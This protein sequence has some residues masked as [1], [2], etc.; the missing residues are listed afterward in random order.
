MGVQLTRTLGFVQVVA[1]TALGLCGLGAML[2]AA[3]WVDG[4]QLLERPARAQTAPVPAQPPLTPVASPDLDV[5][6]YTLEARLDATRHVIAGHGEIRWRNDATT[7][8]HE[9]WMHLYLNA[10]KNDKTLF[11]RSPYGAGRSGAHASDWGYIDV[12][13]LVARELGN[14]DLWPGAA[15]TSPGDPDDQT[16]IR[17]P[18]PTP[19]APGGR[20]TL[21]V[22]FD[23]KLPAILERTGYAGSFHFAGQ[24]FPKL[25]RREPDGSWAHFRFD[26]QSE[27]YADFGSYDVTIDVPAEMQV[28]ASGVRRSERVARGRRVVRHTIAPAHDFAWTAWDQFRVATTTADG[29]AVRLLYPPSQEAGARVTL[30]ALERALPYM[31]RRYGRY[32]YPTLTVVSPPDAAAA[33]GG[34][35]YPS[36]ITSGGRWYLPHL[37]IRAFETV[38]IHELGHQWFYGTVATNEHQW[39]FLDEGVNSYAESNTMTALYGQGSAI[40]ALGVEVSGP[41]LMRAIAALRAHDVPIALG[42][43]RFPGF[44]DLAALVYSRTATLLTTLG[45]V[46]GTERLER[47]LGDYARRNRFGHPGPTE[48]VA[49]LRTELGDEAARAAQGA[50]F[51]RGW[52]DYVVRD[53]ETTPLARPAGVFDSDAGRKEHR[54]VERDDSQPTQWVGRVLVFRHGNLHFPVDIDLYAEDGSTTRHRWDGSGD[55]I[56]LD[57][58]GTSPLVGAWIDP[59]R[60]VALDQDLT[61]NVCNSRPASRARILERASYAAFLLLSGLGT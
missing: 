55:W 48:L 9:L 38:T 36:L 47:A 3:A 60:K 24:W 22:S 54:V 58:R 11:L 33:A 29:V 8:A 13:R 4:A 34:M 41:A 50:L 23:A 45:N 28:G 10:F 14:I 26:A 25:A 42:A 27:F 37:G 32:P 59:R 21:A 5:A 19:V 44:E 31:N 35:E 57:Y 43:A 30:D 49:A 46:Y 51:E 2:W 39:P 6:S 7:P 52:V 56:A 16:D 18:L 15:R 53:L 17:I 1:G 20:L 12:T 40:S 61:N